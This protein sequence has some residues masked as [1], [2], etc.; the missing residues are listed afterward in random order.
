MSTCW[1]SVE[2]ATNISQPSS[3]KMSNI[4]IVN[5]LS[6]PPNLEP[7][8]LA[9]RF[10]YCDLTDFKVNYRV[11][12]WYIALVVCGFGFV[13][14]TANIVVLIKMN[15]KITSTNIVLAGLALANNVVNTEYIPYALGNLIFRTEPN[16]N[17]LTYTWASYVLMHAHVS[18]V[19]IYCHYFCCKSFI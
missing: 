5:N 12:H 7:T 8:S 9:M 1:S 4:G 17:V 11:I 13:M 3:S 19:R 6:N 10:T 18:Q 15:Q 16:A 2:P 14:N